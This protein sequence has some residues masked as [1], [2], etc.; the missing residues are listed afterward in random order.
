MKQIIC[1][2][3]YCLGNACSMVPS[4][5]VRS[6]LI[7]S[8]PLED[9]NL[10]GWT[11]ALSS[12]SCMSLWDHRKLTPS[13]CFFTK[14]ALVIP[15]YLLQKLLQVQTLFILYFLWLNYSP[16]KV[17]PNMPY[18]FLLLW[19]ELCPHWKGHP[20]S[21]ILVTPF[22]IRWKWKSLSC[23]WLFATPWTIQS[24]EFSRPEY[25]SG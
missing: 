13:L 21:Q 19:P 16:V 10:L 6:F 5:P 7:K 11:A 1:D 9:D 14:E 4:L 3:E 23:V 17:L 12:P 24:V 8:H 20:P 18:A 15:W 2:S 25:W 22:I